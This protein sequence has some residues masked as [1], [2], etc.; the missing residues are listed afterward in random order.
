MERG[1]SLLERWLLTLLSSLRVAVE[2][3]AERLVL[4]L[5]HQV[6]VEVEVDRIPFATYLPRYWGQLKLLLLE[7]EGLVERP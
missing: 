4:A 3:L 5:R 6:V 1:P 7:L 2:D